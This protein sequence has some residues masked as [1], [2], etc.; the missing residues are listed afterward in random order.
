MLTVRAV[1]SIALA[2]RVGAGKHLLLKIL[3]GDAAAR[4]QYIEQQSR[5][6]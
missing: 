2:Q 3:R 5:T 1:E 6:Q 4:L